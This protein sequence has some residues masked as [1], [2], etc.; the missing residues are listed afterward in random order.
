MKKWLYFGIVVWGLWGAYYVYYKDWAALE[1]I[2]TWMLAG[3]LFFAI[4][5]VYQ[6]GK[7]TNA[8]LTVELFRELRS[9]EAKNALR[10]IYKLSAEDVQHLRGEDSYKIESVLDKF[11][12]LGALV[13][14]GIID[15]RLA[16]QIG[17]AALR[18]WYKLVKYI[19]EERRKRGFLFEDY[20]GFAECSLNY[21]R[22]MGIKVLFQREGGTDNIDLVT[23]LQNKEIRP[24][25][26][27]E[28]KKDMKMTK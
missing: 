28:I 2:F 15:K 27:A 3:G 6:A 22:D 13:N 20:E 11:Q 16:I 19:R 8:Q 18:C 1:A 7:N 23:E 25:S 24:R 5:Q 12:L 21:S 17:P 14:Q 26:F 9:E 10:F 4:L